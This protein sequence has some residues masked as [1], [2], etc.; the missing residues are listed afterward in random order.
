MFFGP[1]LDWITVFTGALGFGL[2]VMLRATFKLRGW[3]AFIEQKNH[4]LW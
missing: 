4:Y 3:Q 1:R 2:S